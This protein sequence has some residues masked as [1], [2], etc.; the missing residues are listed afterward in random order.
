MKR[1]AIVLPFALALLL[2]LAAGPSAR[3][4]DAAAAWRTFEGSWSASGHRESLPTEGSRVA[5]SSYLS[6]ALVLTVTD[7]SLNKGFRWEAIGFDDGVKVS[8]VRCVW[9]DQRGDRIF[10]TLTGEVMADG[11]R[12]AGTI[13]GGTGRYAGI[14]G[15]YAFKWQFVVEAE[16]GSIQGRAVN[17]KGRY[18]AK[19]GGQ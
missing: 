2:P 15:D 19:G 9:T 4:Q 8:V 6:G 10:S 1:A 18:R 17:L 16:K 11:R 13:T 5:S 14:E 7:A 3:G 12:F